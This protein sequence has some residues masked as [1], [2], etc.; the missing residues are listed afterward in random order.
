MDEVGA[1]IRSLFLA[2]PLPAPLRDELL[3]AYDRLAAEDLPEASFAGPQETYLNVRGRHAGERRLG[4]G[5]WGR[6]SSA[7]GWTPTS[8]RSSN[9]A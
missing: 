4:A 1:A 2:G 3:A 7:A 9:R 6:P 5:G 8:T